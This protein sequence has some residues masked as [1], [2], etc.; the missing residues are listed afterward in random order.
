MM[1][2]VIQVH[3]TT[4]PGDYYLGCIIYRWGGGGGMD[5]CYNDVFFAFCCW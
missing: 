1:S 2:K 4:V 5:T 3:L